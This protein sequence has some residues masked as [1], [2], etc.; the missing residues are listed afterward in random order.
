MIAF[1]ERVSYVFSGHRP[2]Q[3]LDYIHCKETLSQCH[4]SEHVASALLCC[5]TFE[6]I[7]HN[8]KSSLS[9]LQCEPWDLPQKRKLLEL[10]HETLST[11][12]FRSLS[13]SDVSDVSELKPSFSGTEAPNQTGLT[14]PLNHSLF[15]LS[16]LTFIP[17]LF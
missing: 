17:L 9:F 8:W 1:R 12:S 14:F 13:L 3:I 5:Y 4:A 2:P 16:F 11:D 6:D 10:E 15:L 7:V